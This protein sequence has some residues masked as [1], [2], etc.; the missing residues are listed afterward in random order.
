MRTDMPDVSPKGIYNTTETCKALGVSYNTLR[1]MVKN[2][3]IRYD[4]RC[5]G[6]R[7]ARTVF[8][9]EDIIRAWRGA[10]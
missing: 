5:C 7:R 10:L 2:R 6:T 4:V 3:L 1:L 9:G 8:H